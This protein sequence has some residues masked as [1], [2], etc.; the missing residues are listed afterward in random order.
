MSL[1]R[2]STLLLACLACVTVAVAQHGEADQ[3]L[4]QGHLAQAAALVPSASRPGADTALYHLQADLAARRRAWSEALEKHVDV[5]ALLTGVS[6]LTLD[7]AKRVAADTAAVQTALKEGGTLPLLLALT[8]WR[9]AEVKSAYQHW[10]ATLQHFEQAAYLEDLVA[11]YRSFV[12]ELDTQVGPQS[13]KEMPAKTFPFPS[14]LALKG[15][16]I[17]LEAEIARLGYQQTLRKAI[18][19][20]TRVFF[21]I[22]FAAK[23]LTITRANR[24]LVGQ[25]E[26]ITR[27]Q[28]QVGGAKQVDALKAQ[29]LL[30]VLDNKILTYERQQLNATAQANALL[31]LPLHTPWGV[32]SAVDLQDHM[33]SIEEALQQVRTESQELQKAARDAELMLTMV[34]MAETMLY[35]RASVGGSQIAPSL[36]AEAGPTRQDMAAFPTMPTVSHEAAGFGANAA[37]IDE[38]RIRVKQAQAM[39]DN[40]TAQTAFMAQDAHYRADVS[41][42][43]MKTLAETVVP[44]AKQAFDATR[45]QYAAARVPFNDFFEV[46]RTHLEATLMLEEARRDLNKA[47]TDLQDATGRTASRL[48]VKLAK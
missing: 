48:L 1:L 42:R 37:Y 28:L 23:A 47:L 25:M 2:G 7:K 36:G 20:A 33:L 14:V 39:R 16:I 18:N 8:A 30:A 15:Q 41:R 46:S 5:E 9:N 45:E 13:H 6:L 22:Q 26:A 38:L 10:R 17:D 24:D 34:R 44:R 19:D 35:P 3:D 27:E 21:D 12:R 43:E 29:S 31:A 4:L 32:G 11:Q 40:A